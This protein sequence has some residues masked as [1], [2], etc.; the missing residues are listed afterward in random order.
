MLDFQKSIVWWKLST[1]RLGYRVV[2]TPLLKTWAFVFG[3]V[4]PNLITL[5]KLSADA[6]SPR[7]EP[8][9]KITFPR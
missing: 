7:I 3:C 5:R 1:A 6:A 2:N 4:N 9:G 8:F